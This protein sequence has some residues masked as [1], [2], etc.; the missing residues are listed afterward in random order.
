M[1]SWIES[2]NAPHCHFP[3]QNLPYGVFAK[4]GEEPRCGVAIGDMVVDMA[5]LESAGLLKAGGTTTVFD[6]PTLNDF[7]GLG[8]T[9]WDSIREQL[10]S[11][12]AKG[13]NDALSG[14]DTLK[15]KALVPMSAAQMFLPFAV[16]EYTDFYAGKQH[17]MNIGTILRGA[18]NALPPNW[19]HIPIGYNGRASTVIVSGTDIKRPLGQTKAPTAQVPSFKACARLDIELEM[20]AVVGTPSTMGQPITVQEA[21][22]MIFGYVLLNDWSARDIQGW[23][24]Q[25]LGPFQA[26]AFATSISPWVVTKAALESFRT[27][28]PEREKELLPYLNE[29][30]PMIYDIEL[31]AYM[32]PEGA[33]KAT[34]LCHTNYN[35]MYYSAAQQ[36]THHAIGGCKMNTGDLLGSGTISGAERCE[37]GSLMELTWGGKEPITLDS[38]ESRTFIEDGDTLTLTGWAQGDGFR[39]GFGECTGKILPAPDFKA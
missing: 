15:A 14:N 1:T 16:S 25:P 35:R 3:I 17:A 22:D 21:D 28:T 8:K 11:L 29:P 5:V 7:M 19:L 34:L 12:F 38:G 26:K 10:T 36:L 33:D 39:I 18:E 4:N 37:F 2:A 20:G 9:S 23:E 27:S 13:G 32:Q 30:G 6:K 31:Q 24:Y